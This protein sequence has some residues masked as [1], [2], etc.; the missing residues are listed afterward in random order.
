MTLWTAANSRL[1][2]AQVWSFRR[3]IQP[4]NRILDSFVLLSRWTGCHFINKTEPH[5][6]LN[7]CL[8]RWINYGKIGWLKMPCLKCFNSAH[9][10]TEH[11]NCKLFY[12]CV[13]LVFVWSRLDYISLP[14]P[15]SSCLTVLQ[16]WFGLPALLAS[17][18]TPLFCPFGQSFGLP[19]WTVYAMSSAQ[20]IDD[21]YW[22]LL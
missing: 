1:R 20:N 5:I 7:I 11:M 14:L 9:R 12:C 18:I 21:N 16:S 3:L 15:C 17:L 22:W 19:T 4:L 2:K 8:G 13:K 10:I 6:Y